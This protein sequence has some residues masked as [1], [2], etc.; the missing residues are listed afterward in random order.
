MRCT[1]INDL[2]YLKPDELTS[3]EIKAV[4]AHIRDCKSCAKEFSEIMKA[5]EFISKLKNAE[6]LLTGETDFTNEVMRNIANAESFTTENIFNT[7]IDRLTDFFTITAVRATAVSLILILVSIFTIQ[8]YAVFNSVS[9]LEDK[10]AVTNVSVTAVQAGFNDVKVFKLAADLIGMING[11]QFY[12]EITGNLA[13]T[14]KTKLNEFLSLYSDLQH[15]KTLYSRE[16]EEKYPELNSFLGKKLSLEEL[17]DFVKKNEN[18]IKE[19]SR[20]IPAGGK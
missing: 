17:S 4:Q 12:T 20:K 16:I 11:D 19:F 13:L 15:Y 7:I 8:Q 10:L 5:N 9:S 3:E 6:P 14:N 1:K 2:L 18:L